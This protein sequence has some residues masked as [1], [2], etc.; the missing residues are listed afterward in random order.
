MH[1]IMIPII[2]YCITDVS[3]YLIELTYIRVQIQIKLIKSMEQNPLETDSRSSTKEIPP[4][5]RNSEF[6]LCY[7]FAQLTLVL[8]EMNPVHI[9]SQK[10]SACAHPSFCPTLLFRNSQVQKKLVKTKDLPLGETTPVK[11]VLLQL[12]LWA[13]VRAS[14][15]LLYFLL[16]VAILTVMATGS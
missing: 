4:S 5:L 2:I 9:V 14:V 6:H 3:C 11:M 1:P 15:F 12:H 7:N 16:R 13:G 8:C 10:P